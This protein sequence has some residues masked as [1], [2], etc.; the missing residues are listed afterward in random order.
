MSKL[1]DLLKAEKRYSF[2]LGILFIIYILLGF[3][4]PVALANI[5]DNV[6]GN[7]IIVLLA[8]SI[9]TQIHPIVGVLGFIAAYELIRRSSKVTGTFAIRNYLPSEESKVMDFSK[10]NDYP[11]T[12]EEEVVKKMAPLVETPPDQD[13]H[14]KPILD[15]IHDAAPI[16]YNGVI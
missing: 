11:V 16:D 9:F 12:L 2:L 1:N 15:G 6:I 8:I 10:Y 3:D 7:I 5:I 13:L 4:T 14:Y